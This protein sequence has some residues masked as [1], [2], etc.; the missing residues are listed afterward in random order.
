MTTNDIAPLSV[1]KSHEKRECLTLPF[2]T[3]WYHFV[4][5]LEIFVT[6][7]GLEPKTPTLKV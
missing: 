2:V 5:R 4:I 3:R 1:L 7:L 6:R